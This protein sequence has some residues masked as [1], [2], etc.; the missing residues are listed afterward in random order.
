[1]SS[2]V[3][4]QKWQYCIHRTGASVFLEKSY[5]KIRSQK[6]SSQSK[7]FFYLDFFIK[8]FRK[9]L[10]RKDLKYVSVV[11]I[12]GK[13]YLTDH[14][15]SLTE[16]SIL[17]FFSCKFDCN[18]LEVNSSLRKHLSSLIVYAVLFHYI[19]PYLGI[20]SFNWVH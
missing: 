4:R 12:W 10:Y 20:A 7:K 3:S 9:N 1:M 5:K 8:D 19:F 6:F 11:A 16:D 13:I 2:V 15:K 17:L 18:S 14:S